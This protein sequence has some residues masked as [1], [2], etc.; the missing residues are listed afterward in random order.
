MQDIIIG[1]FIYAEALHVS[2]ES[3][4]I[5]WLLCENLRIDEC[6]SYS[7]K[8]TCNRMNQTYLNNIE[9]I[10]LLHIRYMYRP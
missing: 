7:I 5:H 6:I 10:D 8:N 9:I 2:T 1:V 3:R 4:F